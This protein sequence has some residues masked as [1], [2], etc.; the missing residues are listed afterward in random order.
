MLVINMLKNFDNDA[1][2]RFCW[3]D[4]NSR[5]VGKKEEKKPTATRPITRLTESNLSVNN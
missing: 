5:E 4:N 3:S 1:S 2:A